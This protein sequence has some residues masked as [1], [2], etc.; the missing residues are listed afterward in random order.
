MISKLDTQIHGSTVMLPLTQ[1]N[2]LINNYKE[3]KKAC[4]EKDKAL[5]YLNEEIKQYNGQFTNKE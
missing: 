2:D 1:F 3:L 4:K 5:T